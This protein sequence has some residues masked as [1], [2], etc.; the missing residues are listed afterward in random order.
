[1]ALITPRWQVIFYIE[2]GD[3]N[4]EMGHWM[5]GVHDG[6]CTEQVGR[7]PPPVLLHPRWCFCGSSMMVLFG[8]LAASAPVDSMGSEDSQL[9]CSWFVHQVLDGC[10]KSQFQNVFVGM[11]W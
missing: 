10:E 6:D 4:H 1:M 5:V 11:Y 3:F 7:R 8:P 2:R 9:F